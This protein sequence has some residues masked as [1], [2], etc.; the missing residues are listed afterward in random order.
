M[1]L[2]WSLKRIT[3]SRRPVFRQQ[4]TNGASQ[5]S[6]PPRS[7][8][9]LCPKRREVWDLLWLFPDAR[10]LAAK[11]LQN[12]E[13]AWDPVSAIYLLKILQ[14]QYVY[15]A[16]GDVLVETGTLEQ[17]T[18][19]ADDVLNLLDI[20]SNILVRDCSAGIQNDMAFEV[21]I[22]SLGLLGLMKKRNVNSPSYEQM[23][24]VLLDRVDAAFRKGGQILAVE[25][26]NDMLRRWTLD[27]VAEVFTSDTSRSSDHPS[28]AGIFARPE[29]AK[30]C[31][32]PELP[33]LDT[34]DP[35]SMHQVTIHQMYCLVLE[36]VSLSYHGQRIASAEVSAAV[37][38]LSR[39]L[40][41]SVTGRA[42][43]MLTRE[44]ERL[45][46]MWPVSI[47]DTTKDPPELE[48]ALEQSRP[49]WTILY[50][51][52]W[53]ANEFGH[54]EFFADARGFCIRTIALCE[55]KDGLK[56]LRLKA[57][58]VLQAIKLA[59]F[60]QIGSDSNEAASEPLLHS[61][62]S[63]EIQDAAGISSARSETTNSVE[64]Q[65]LQ[66]I[67]ED[68]GEKLLHFAR[69][70]ATGVSTSQDSRAAPSSETWESTSASGISSNHRSITASSF[71]SVTSNELSVSKR[72][73]TCRYSQ[74]SH[75]QC[76]HQV[77][78]RHRTK[79]K[80]AESF[81]LSPDNNYAAYGFRR[82][83]EVCNLFNTTHAAMSIE[84][85]TVLSL[86]RKESLVDVAISLTHV[87]GISDDK[88]YL[89]EYHALSKNSAKPVSARL[90]PDCQPTCVAIS[91]NSDIIAIGQKARRHHSASASVENRAVLQL[92]NT[93]L[94][95]IACLDCPFTQNLELPRHITFSHDA[96][97]LIC[98]G[99]MS[100]YA[101]TR[102]GSSMW[103]EVALGQLG[104]DS[105][106]NECHG[107]TSVT[108]FNALSS[109]HRQS[110]QSSATGSRYHY[111]LTSIQTSIRDNS[112]SFVAP[113]F[114]NSP[115]KSLYPP[116][117][118]LLYASSASESG[119]IVA[120]LTSSG[121]VKV[122][123]L[124]PSEGEVTGGLRMVPVDCSPP[125]V[126]ADS[127]DQA[128]KVGVARD[129]VDFLIVAADRHGKVSHTKLVVTHK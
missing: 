119:E 95:P 102:F 117:E 1:T 19:T 71:S 98:G 100:Y 21:M 127:P 20:T 24:I 125:K 78:L 27:M 59:K 83:V 65:G 54:L 4:S 123:Q 92:Y 63:D 61:S 113:L 38:A 109:Q 70:Q 101:W 90:E 76:M 35:S 124:E 126:S 120:F 32:L 10:G 46:T 56:V 42:G 114:R 51:V 44:Y 91:P 9:F 52:E 96:K 13:V 77:R 30:H 93:N 2:P 72:A 25:N 129:G 57:F 58:D 50:L 26:H 87:V 12:L 97:V 80:P 104:M 106:V 41:A 82:D 60:G 115:F 6:L 31:G 75:S 112:S 118:D 128:G 105:S 103:R 48:R 68:L 11:F 18:L 33:N 40:A 28:L 7:E 43:S 39:A 15:V 74:A 85:D 37:M 22:S 107:I 55:G 5:V 62:L 79:A 64:L 89:T 29:Q 86:S 88:V 3:G 73:Q 47:H 99:D 84:A 34:L 14:V 94:E 81:A 36:A 53:L 69:R 111:L 110:D 121:E 17:S 67:I 45:M 122:F 116:S 108:P 66:F 49:A 16:G 8:N 23:R